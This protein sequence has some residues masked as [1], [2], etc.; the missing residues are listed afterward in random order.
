MQIDIFVIELLETGMRQGCSMPI[1]R[2]VLW[3]SPGQ[4]GRATWEIRIC[5]HV[6]HSPTR[7]LPHARRAY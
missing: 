3:L 5:V 6:F 2:S 1:L 4:Y 7:S